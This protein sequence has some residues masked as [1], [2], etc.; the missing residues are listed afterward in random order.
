[1]FSITIP[2]PTV[3]LYVMGALVVILLVKVVLSYVR[4]K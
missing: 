1:M 3:L 4:G 2:V